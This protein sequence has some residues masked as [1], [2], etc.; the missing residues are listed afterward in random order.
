M[1]ATL[2]SII[3]RTIIRNVDRYVPNKLRPIWEHE[4][5]PKTVFFWAPAIKWSLVI[6]GISDIARPVENL[7]IGQ[8]ISLTATGLIWS[9]YSLVIIPKNWSLFSVNFFVATTQI[10]QL[11]RIIIYHHQQQQPQ[12]Q[13]KQLEQQQQQSSITIDNV[14]QS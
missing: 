8:T 3:Y 14:K 5:G 12:S 9:R 2:P 4:A 1:A 6:A 7:S 10:T 11:C 13:R